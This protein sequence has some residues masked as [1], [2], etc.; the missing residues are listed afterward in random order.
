MKKIAIYCVNYNS[1][2]S[3][4]RYMAS[5]DEAVR[6]SATEVECHKFIADNTPPNENIGYFP[7]IRKLMQENPPFDYEYV[8]ISNVDVLL[9][10]DFFTQLCALNV[11]SDT[12]WIAPEI[13]S[14]TEHRDR[15][16]KILNRYPKRK[17]EVLRT[18]FSFPPLYNLYTLTLYKSKK[19]LTHKRGQIYAGHGSFII[20]TNEF[21]K[22]CGIINYP[23]F[24]FCEEIY[25][26]E[27]CKQGNLKVMYEPS[28]KVIDSEHASTSS[29]RRSRYCRYNYDAICHILRTYY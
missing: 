13:Y 20:L 3:L 15:N 2:D 1:Y 17:L 5:I 24:L 23:V 27:E 21:M 28:V 12:G 4:E 8:I 10:Q 18:L 14:Q 26:G 7:A 16:P 22:R 11:E 9:P 19:L 29:F 6:C 25:L